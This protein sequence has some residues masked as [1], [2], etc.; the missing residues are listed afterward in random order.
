M[1]IAHSASVTGTALSSTT[2]VSATV[3][4]VAN[5]F[6]VAVIDNRNRDVTSVV[7]S[8]TA[9]TWTKAVEQCSGRNV[10]IVEIWTAYGSPGSDFTVTATFG[11]ASNTALIT[12]STLTGVDSGTPYYDPVGHST[13]GENAACGGTGTDGTALELTTGSTTA[14]D[15]HFAAVGPR[16]SALNTADGDYTERAHP[17]AGAGGELLH[18]YIETYEKPSSG[19][20]TWNGTTSSARDWATAGFVIKAA[21]A[22]AGTF[23]PVPKRLPMRPRR[24]RR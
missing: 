18:L 9:M 23:P 14:N 3:T 5:A 2:V 11:T 16:N 10:H 13:L 24:L 19:D 8:L 20:N 21:A 15:W 7:D 1:A 22:P 17:N 12:V 4:A 6:Y